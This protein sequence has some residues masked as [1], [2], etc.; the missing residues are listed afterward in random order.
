MRFGRHADSLEY[1]CVTNKINSLKLESNDGVVDS[2]CGYFQLCSITIVKRGM[3][4]DG[5]SYSI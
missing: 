2:K 3:Q 1:I 4:I 5:N